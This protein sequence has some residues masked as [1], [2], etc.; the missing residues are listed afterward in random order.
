MSAQ[1]RPDEAQDRAMSSG[2]KAGHIVGS[3]PFIVSTL[4]YIEPAP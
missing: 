1:A 4:V 2:S 3:L